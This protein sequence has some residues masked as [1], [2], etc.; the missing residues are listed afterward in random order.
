MRV[1]Y[2][3]NWLPAT[4]FVVEQD[5]ISYVKVEIPE[6]RQ[7]PI[8][9][10]DAFEKEKS[11]LARVQFAD[12]STSYIVEGLGVVDMPLDDSLLFV[13]VEADDDYDLAR[14]T[15]THQKDYLHLNL[16]SR[17]WLEKLASAASIEKMDGQG[18]VVSYVESV[19]NDQFESFLS[20]ATLDKAFFNSKGELVDKIEGGGGVV[21]FNVP[22]GLKTF[23]VE[24]VNHELMS[25]QLIVADEDI[26]N[27]IQSK[28]E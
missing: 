3:G 28:F 27:V 20:E 18:T 25:T 6:S 5:H 24:S 23:T 9:V 4:A 26:V 1:F 2:E 19:N 12:R 7:I 17:D 14:I 13:E 16:P 15:S 22:P 11:L 8:R 10:A 21:Y